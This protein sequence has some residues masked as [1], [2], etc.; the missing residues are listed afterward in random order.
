MVNN[1]VS[2][3]TKELGIGSGLM[4]DETLYVYSDHL[5]GEYFVTDEDYENDICPQCGDSDTLEYMGTYD[6]IL[7]YLEEDIKRAQQ[8]YGIVKCALDEYIKRQEA[9]NG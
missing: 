1:L 8:N 9:H 4:N 3:T 6:E 2:A 7:Y 5:Y